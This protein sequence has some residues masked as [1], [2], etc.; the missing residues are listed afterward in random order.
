MIVASDQLGLAFPHGNDPLT[1]RES[2][3]WDCTAAKTEP[4]GPHH[5]F[6]LVSPRLAGRVTFSGSIE[7]VNRYNVTPSLSRSIL[8]LHWRHLQ[9]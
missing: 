4:F 8:S 9:N 2:S 1:F 6:T 5:L 3:P 7:V